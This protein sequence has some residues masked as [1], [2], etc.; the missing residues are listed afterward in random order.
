MVE[1]RREKPKDAAAIRYV[2]EQAF[3]GSDEADLV[4]VLR[5]ADKVPISLVAIYDGQ[6]VGHIL[7][8][9]VTVAS[10]PSAYRSIGLAPVGV[11]PE[12]Q[13]RGIGSLLIQEGL[14]ECREAR[15][16]IAVVLGDPVYYS[17]F[18][19]SRA[20]DYG[21]GNE[22]GV[23]EHFMAIEFRTGALAKVS[24]TVRYQPEFNSSC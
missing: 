12:I 3:R 11:L 22:Y 13:R 10:A 4:E 6:V 17:R 24:G 9:P 7:F 19:F 21:L 1:I 14:R 2:L 16:D 8:S 23:D 5:K 20:A 15:Y 18:G